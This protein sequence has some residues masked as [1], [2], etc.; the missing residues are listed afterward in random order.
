MQSHSLFLIL[1]TP[2]TVNP[3]TWKAT[4]LTFLVQPKMSIT[5]NSRGRRLE[6]SFAQEQR[7]YGEN[8]PEHVTLGNLLERCSNA[9][10]IPVNRIKLLHSKVLMKDS[11][12]T[13]SSYGVRTGSKISMLRDGEKFYDVPGSTPTSSPSRSE[14]EYP[15]LPP[16][17]APAPPSTS[18]TPSNAPPL[19]PP[20]YVNH[21]DKLISTIDALLDKVNFE[22]APQIADYATSVE[23]IRHR[24]LTP[25]DVKRLQDTS[26]RCGEML[27]QT[28]LKIDGV[29]VGENEQARAKRKEAVKMVQGLMDRVDGLKERVKEAVRE[30]GLL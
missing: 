13:L 11:S 22:I 30:R 29:T 26:L 15:S 17:A 6:L 10:Q 27:M 20:K 9:S 4:S 1:R 8:W 2:A 28:L 3:V 23:G 24:N 14:P 18:G 12:A 21:K 7:M 5:V 16:R 25:H 19:A